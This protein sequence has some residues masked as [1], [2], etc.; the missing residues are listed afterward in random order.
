MEL[1]TDL[2][3]TAEI[4]TDTRTDVVVIPIIALTVR[5]REEVEADEESGAVPRRSGAFDDMEGV[6]VVEDGIVSFREVTIG[7]AGTEYFEV[8]SG[9]SVGDSLVAGPY[10]IIRQLGVGDA[11]RHREGVIVE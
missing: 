8:L 4:V 9:V 6:F 7:I 10:Q 11:V 2:S 5:D 3:A 1:R